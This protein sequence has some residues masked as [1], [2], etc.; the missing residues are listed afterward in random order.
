[1][2]TF[3]SIPD[4]EQVRNAPLYA[5]IKSLFLSIIADCPDYR[6]ED[7]GY[8]VLMEP[9]DVDHV[10]DDLDMPY[11]LSE[12]PFEG[13]TMIDGWMFPRRLAAQQPVRPRLPDPGRRVVARRCEAI[14]GC[15]SGSIA[16][17][18]KSVPYMNNHARHSVGFF[19]EDYKWITFKS[20]P[21]LQQLNRDDSAFPAITYIKEPRLRR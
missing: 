17:A 2:K 12:V 10:L 19:K 5:S 18:D 11:K 3:K 16:F 13:V 15:T 9:G 20:H 8:L 6:P 4:L 1:M 21:D 14:S 7:D